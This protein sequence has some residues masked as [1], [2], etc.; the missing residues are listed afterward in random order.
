[1]KV[2]PVILQGVRIALVPME[3][4]HLSALRSIERSGTL[5]VCEI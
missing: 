3:A 4:S 5:Q 1:M 2:E